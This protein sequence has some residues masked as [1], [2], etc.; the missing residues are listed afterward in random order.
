MRK[1]A[2]AAFVGVVLAQHALQAV[3]PVVPV[4]IKGSEVRSQL[5][6]K[7]SRLDIGYL[8]AKLTSAA[9]VRIV[10]A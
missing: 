2:G 8:C 6:P 9:F 5:W 7:N 1:V 10:L 3:A 4:N